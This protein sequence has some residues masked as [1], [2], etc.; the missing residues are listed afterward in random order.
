MLGGEDCGENLNPS[1]LMPTGKI[2]GVDDP[3]IS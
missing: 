1:K 2:I 3:R